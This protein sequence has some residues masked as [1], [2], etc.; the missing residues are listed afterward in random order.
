MSTIKLYIDKYDLSGVEFPSR[1][2]D[3]NKFELN[4][5]S[6]ALNVLFV[7]CNTK[8][9]RSAYVSKHNSVKERNLE[10]KF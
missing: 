10:R 2:K 8:Q 4:D 9:I 6:V 7:L 3:R 5:K 1:K